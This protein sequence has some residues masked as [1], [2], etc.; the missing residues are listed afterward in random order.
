ME[1]GLG[2]QLPD[3]RRMLSPHE[4]AFALSFAFHDHPVPTLL[5]AAREGRLTTR[6]DV[7][8]A[9][10]ARLESPQLLRGS[11]PAARRN[12]APWQ[13]GKLSTTNAAKPRMLRFF[14]EYFDYARAA[15]VFKDDIRH[16]GVHNPRYIIQDAD[17]FVLSILATDRNVLEQL[18]TS[19][20]YYVAYKRR[21]YTQYVD[22]YNL[23]PDDRSMDGPSQ[24]PHGQRAGMLTHPA[25]LVAHS[26]N[27]ETDPVRRGRWIQE[28][29][30]GGV[31]PDLPIGV[32]AQLPEEPHHTIR[33]QFRV[34][35]A[36]ECWRCHRKMNP[37]GEPFEIYDDFG[38]FRDVHHVSE[39]GHVVA[40]ILEVGRKRRYAAAEPGPSVDATGEL[41][42]TGDPELDGGVSDA[43][44]LVRRLA[45]SARVRQVF[46][47]HVFRFW[48]GRNETMDD[49]PV[50]MA[51][52][53][54]YVESNGSFNEVLVAL[55]TS[56][57]F[58]Y[59]R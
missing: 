38:R 39:H 24:L 25:W 5:E 21:N 29:L 7:E 55:L 59:R 20:D 44:D 19:D 15:E 33:E 46:L 14:R 1:M 37:L 16:G 6:E 10:R 11:V 27:F 12:D 53:R 22:V 36:R 48:M 35:R 32:A 47:R 51:M 43:I 45:K 34:V 26:G 9:V 2:S 40:S 41:R 28:H 8:R 49:S 23:E 17:W 18:L 52:D 50:L 3:G 58:L 13:V 30:L 54:M 56:D 31:V 4:L 57:A 42:G